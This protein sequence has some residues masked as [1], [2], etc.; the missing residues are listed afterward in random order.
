MDKLKYIKLEQEDGSYSESIPLSVDADHV[1]INGHSLTIELNR[2]DNLETQINKKPY[3][4]VNIASMKTDGNLKEGDTCQTLGYYSAND[5]GAGLYKVVNDSTLI[6]NGGNIHA[7]ANGLKATLFINDKRLNVKQF[8]AYGDG[9]HNDTQYIQN[10]LSFCRNKDLEIFFPKSSAYLIGGTFKLNSDTSI[11]F[12][13]QIIYLNSSTFFFNDDIDGAPIKIKNIKIKNGYFK[14]G[15]NEGKLLKFGLLKAENITIENNIFEECCT[16]NHIFDLGGCKN[17]YIYMNYFHNIGESEYG[18]EGEIIQLDAAYRL[19]LPYWTALESELYDNSGCSNIYIRD[20]IFENDDERTMNAIGSHVVLEETIHKYIY[21][22]DNI[23]DECNYSCIK[24]MRWT[25]FYISR[26][27]FNAKSSSSDTKYCIFI[28]HGY[29]SDNNNESFISADNVH[30]TENKF[31][32][33]TSRNTIKAIYAQAINVN[34][35]IYYHKSLIINNNDYTGAYASSELPGDDFITIKYIDKVIISNNTINSAKNA[36][37]TDSVC[38]TVIIS[39][40]IL[41]GCR[42]VDGLGTKVLNKIFINTVEVDNQN[43]LINLYDTVSNSI[44]DLSDSTVTYTLTCSYISAFEH[45]IVRNDNMVSIKGVCKLDSSLASSSNDV[46]FATIPLGYRP[47]QTI[48]IPIYFAENNG[49]NIKALG[50]M[51][52]NPNGQVYIRNNTGQSYS[53][54]IIDTTYSII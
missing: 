33:T 45:R 9:I 13:N 44:L 47:V 4:Y 41:K 8:G 2:I 43:N 54:F 26:N 40:N 22:E 19:G 24:A 51:S 15:I 28:T 50:N 18:Q 49:Y 27:V 11:D 31:N 1:D 34:D 3:Y 37:W 53:F 39:G 29:Y 5:G 32:L 17:I 52:I 10:C 30:I 46:R 25:D 7:L 14:A 23:F 48:R 6:D 36:F 12:N 35:T 20:N 38:N 16:S 21:I 42:T